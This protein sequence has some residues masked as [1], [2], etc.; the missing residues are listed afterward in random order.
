MY[1]QKKI[2]NSLVL[3]FRNGVLLKFGKQQELV[4]EKML[5]YTIKTFRYMK[6]PEKNIQEFLKE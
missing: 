2:V 5:S 1:S 6:K 4:F 3:G